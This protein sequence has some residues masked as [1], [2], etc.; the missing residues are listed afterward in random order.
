MTSSNIASCLEGIGNEE[1]KKNFVTLMLKLD[2]R[3]ELIKCS[4]ERYFKIWVIRK[5]RNKR[6]Y[7]TDFY[8]NSRDK[9]KPSLKDVLNSIKFI[10][11]VPEKYNEYRV[12]W[13][14][15]PSK[16]EHVKALKLA[17]LF[18]GILDKT[19][20]KNIPHFE[21]TSKD[22][23]IYEDAHF[24]AACQKLLERYSKAMNEKEITR[25]KKLG[26]TTIRLDKI[27]E[28]NYLLDLLRN[29]HHSEKLLKLYGFDEEGKFNSRNFPVPRSDKELEGINNDIR[30]YKNEL[31]NSHKYLEWLANKYGKNVSS[32][33]AII[34]P[35]SKFKPNNWIKPIV[36]YLS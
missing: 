7:F 2:I 6:T 14:P 4:K 16:K 9:F 8:R 20:V 15:E 19:D 33:G 13:F 29:V 12:Q 24:H 18:K 1:L 3:L 35:P 22:G 32:E 21:G 36:I 34:Y 28:Y 10:V 25:C 17:S 26:F 11:D 31:K 27:F 23:K 5:D 30:N